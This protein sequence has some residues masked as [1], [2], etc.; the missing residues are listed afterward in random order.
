MIIPKANGKD[1]YIGMKSAVS[2][3]ITMIIHN[4]IRPIINDIMQNNQFANKQGVGINDNLLAL[5]IVAARYKYLKNEP[6]YIA[7][8]N[9][10]GCYDNINTYQIL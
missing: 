4:R 8:M 10:H 6:L 3:I 7:T 1:R 5:H 9:F 2:K